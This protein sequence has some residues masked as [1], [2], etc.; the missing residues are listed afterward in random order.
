[1]R[2]TEK[3]T[4]LFLKGGLCGY[5]WS[6]LLRGIRV[7]LSHPRGG[8][9]DKAIKWFGLRSIPYGDKRWKTYRSSRASTLPLSPLSPPAPILLAD[10]AFECITQR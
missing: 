4:G 6:F 2:K 3:K 10:R 7:N 9:G 1:M 5:L 8:G